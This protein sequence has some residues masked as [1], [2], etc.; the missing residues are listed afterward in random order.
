MTKRMQKGS[1]CGVSD[2]KVSSR[3]MS[4][5]LTMRAIKDTPAF[6]S[7]TK[8][9]RPSAALKLLVKDHGIHSVDVEKIEDPKLDINVVLYF[10]FR[11]LNFQHHSLIM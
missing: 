3:P 2:D 11:F 1:H 8:A 7:V 10:V 5:A 6:G 4:P 9:E